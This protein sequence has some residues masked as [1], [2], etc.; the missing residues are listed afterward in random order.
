[1]LDISDGIAV[2]AGH[3]A[4]RSDVRCVLDL[5]AV[6]LAGGATIDDLGFGEDFELLAAVED[7]D[8]FA[9]V[10]RVEAGE[11]VA[12]LRDGAPYGLRGY[13]HYR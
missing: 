1:M 8:G 5:D 13:E 9:V 10:G 2:D 7:A 3:L 6:P 4:R 12:T 11:G